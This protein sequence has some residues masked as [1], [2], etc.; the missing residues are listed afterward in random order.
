MKSTKHQL[1]AR[2]H[3]RVRAKIVGTADRPRLVVFKSN[4]HIYAKL[5]DD[6]A[7]A[8]LAA[9]SDAVAKADKKSDKRESA[10]VKVA[11]AKAVGESLAQAALA[12]EIKRVAFDRGGYVY[13]GRVQAVAEGARAGGLI[14]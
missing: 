10:G 4:K 8:T 13:T 12:K 14:F 11:R 3:R 9:A 1:R 7:G 6:Q 5:I 2:R